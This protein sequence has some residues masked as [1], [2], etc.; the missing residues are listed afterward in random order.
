MVLIDLLH[1]NYR[2]LRY[3]RS[4][5]V[6]LL[7]FSRLGRLCT[8]AVILERILPLLLVTLE[9]QCAAVR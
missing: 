9:D 2:H 5:L 3:P 8:D 4:K 7:L 6:C 1:A